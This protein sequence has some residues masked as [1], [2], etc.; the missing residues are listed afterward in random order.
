MTVKILNKM[1]RMYQM[2]NET[3]CTLYSAVLVT[4]F[5][6]C[7]RHTRLTVQLCCKC[8]TTFLLYCCI[9]F[10]FIVFDGDGDGDGGDVA[11]VLV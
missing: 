5:R 11:M 9:V 6:G 8:S 2:R 3:E 7:V 10:L 4:S 1:M